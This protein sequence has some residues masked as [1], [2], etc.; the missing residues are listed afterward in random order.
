M[1]TPWRQADVFPHAM[2]SV[3]QGHTIGDRMRMAFI[4][5]SIHMSRSW[6]GDDGRRAEALARAWL[7]CKGWR[8]LGSRVRTPAGELDIIARKGSRLAFVEVKKRRH[9]DDALQ[10]LRPRQQQRIVRAARCWLAHHPQLARCDI[11]FDLMAVGGLRVLRHVQDAFRPS[12][13]F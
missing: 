4:G 13:P 9:L 3:V 11:R 1:H 7:R 5:E 12:E 10:A 6:H 2:L 8:I